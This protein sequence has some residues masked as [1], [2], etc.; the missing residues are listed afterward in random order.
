MASLI[1][2]KCA[3]PIFLMENINDATECGLIGGYIASGICS[4]VALVAGLLA[5]NNSDVEMQNGK[6]VHTGKKKISY[7]IAT[8]CCISLIWLVVP[9]FASWAN[10]RSWSGYDLQ[11][12]SLTN[13]GL[14]RQQA[15][16]KI[17]NIYQAEMQ[18]NAISSAGTNIASAL[19]AQPFLSR[20]DR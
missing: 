9:L 20:R 4:L 3:V 15:L 13:Q 18:A 14:T 10:G 17:Q 1:N 5:Y 6:Q 12:K 8:F 2:P 16:G 19:Y 11:I 7:L